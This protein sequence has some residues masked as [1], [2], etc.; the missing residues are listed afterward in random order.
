M[1]LV[2]SLTSCAVSGALYKDKNRSVLPLSM[3]GGETFCWQGVG[4]PIGESY[5]GVQ[6]VGWG[7]HECGVIAQPE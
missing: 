5:V 2:L 7:T 1:A 6:P 3:R 4:F